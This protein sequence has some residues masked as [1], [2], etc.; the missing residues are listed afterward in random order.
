MLPWRLMVMILLS[1]LISSRVESLGWNF[2]YLDLYKWLTRI[3]VLLEFLSLPDD[4]AISN[5]F[6]TSFL[7]HALR[8]LYVLVRYN[9]SSERPVTTNG[10]CRI[11]ATALLIHLQL[12]HSWIDLTPFV[13]HRSPLNLSGKCIITSESSIRIICTNQRPRCTAR[14]PKWAVSFLSHWFRGGRALRRV[15]WPQLW[16]FK[17]KCIQFGWNGDE[18]TYVNGCLL[19]RISCEN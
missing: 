12:Y 5:K 8:F 1:F 6:L 9:V 18:P 4:V 14:S 19:L 15:T 16:C 3:T 11:Q 13:A 10:W 7:R 17:W 2:Q